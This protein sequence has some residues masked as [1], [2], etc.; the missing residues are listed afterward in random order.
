M[1]RLTRNQPS[2]QKILVSGASGLIG[3]GIVR[4]ANAKRIQIFELS[5]K[6]S[7]DPRVIHWNYEASE[8]V[9]EF[10]RARLEGMSAAIHLSGAN[11]N[12]HRWTDSYKK[13]IVE[14]RTQSTRGLIRVFSQLK[15][16]P[17]TFLCASAT[18]IYGDR[19]DDPVTEDSPVGSGFLAEVCALWEKEAG[20]ARELGIRTISTRFGVVLAKE[21]GALQE[22]L[23]IF[24]LGLGGK[25]G[26]GQQWM[27]WIALEDLISAIFYLLQSDRLSGPVNLVAPEPVRNI[28]FTRTLAGV[29]HRPAF[30]AAPAFALRIG[31]GEMADEALLASTRALPVKLYQDGF[32]FRLPELEPALKTLLR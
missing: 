14:S 8:P 7:S 21:G 25:L 3:T 12:S 28:E 16:P 6:K 24:R 20:R 17:E 5:R 19:G 23:R 15:Q 9:S 13:E 4:V 22:M 10:D 26:S 31:L 32:R 29:L 30:F 18:G 2:E 1:E 27:S 11:L